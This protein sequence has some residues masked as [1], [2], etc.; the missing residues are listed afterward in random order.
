MSVTWSVQVAEALRGFQRHPITGWVRK[1]VCEL[2]FDGIYGFPNHVD[3][4]SILVGLGRRKNA[5]KQVFQNSRDDFTI[6]RLIQRHR[7]ERK[8]IGMAKIKSCEWVPLGVFQCSGNLDR[9]SNALDH[10]ETNS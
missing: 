8:F 2:G 5:S 1:G 7:T 10:F 9:A 4:I 3:E 6:L